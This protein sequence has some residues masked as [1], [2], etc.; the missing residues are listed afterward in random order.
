MTSED[1]G[2]LSWLMAEAH[3]VAVTKGWWDG[4]N[5]ADVNHEAVKVANVHRE[6]SEA[7]EA[8]S[9]GNPL[10]EKIPEFT[11]LEE[12]LADVLL[13]VFDVAEGLNLLLVEA[14]NAKLRY[15]KNRTRRHGGKLL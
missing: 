12:E 3:N 10:S 1:I 7:M 11:Q 13:R 2:D 5:D 14:V 15:N 8:I 4:Y 6:V 9:R